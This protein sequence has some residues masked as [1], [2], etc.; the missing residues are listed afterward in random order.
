MEPTPGVEGGD[1]GEAQEQRVGDLA[2]QKVLRMDFGVSGPVPQ[3]PRDL[4]PVFLHLTQRFCTCDL[5]SQGLGEVRNVF[6]MLK[7]LL[8]L[9][10]SF[11][12]YIDDAKT[13]VGKMARIVLPVFA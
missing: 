7:A 5:C 1:N 9:L 8:A 13:A 2:L 11:D 10:H 12:V 6:L 4:I 3:L